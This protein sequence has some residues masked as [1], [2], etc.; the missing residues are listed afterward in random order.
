M[1]ARGV[2]RAGTVILGAG[3]STRMG[4]PKLVLP[5]AR[6]TVVGHLIGLWHSLGIAEVAVVISKESTALI[7]ELD[8]LGFDTSRRI[9]NDKARTGMFSSVQA[10]ARWPDWGPDLTHLVLTL[11]DQPQIS[12]DTLRRLLRFAEDNPDAICQPSRSGRPKHPIIFPREAL[13]QLSKTNA[14][15]LRAFLEGTALPRQFL[16][17]ADSSLDFDLDTPEDYLAARKRFDPLFVGD[18]AD[19]EPSS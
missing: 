10:A 7:Q 17:V 16:D 13:R 8:R 1:G 9:L 19:T 12:S 2:F 5:W 6:T 18:A 14:E 15:S 11:G 3:A 4:R